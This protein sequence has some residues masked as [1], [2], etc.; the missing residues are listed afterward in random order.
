MSPST[1]R[2]KNVFSQGFRGSARRANMPVGYPRPTD[3]S[4][5]ATRERTP[6]ASERAASPA[7]RLRP[8][9]VRRTLLRR[10][11]PRKPHTT[12]VYPRGGRSPRRN[13]RPKS[14]DGSPGGRVDLGGTDRR[15]A[16][17]DRP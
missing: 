3:R 13:R 12:T 6:P 8:Q 1:P 11:L 16:N 17:E 5:P 15:S 10:H 14:R 4:L 9:S 7:A 2:L